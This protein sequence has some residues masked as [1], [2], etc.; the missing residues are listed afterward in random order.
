[1]VA[2]A[3]IGHNVLQSME[4]SRRAAASLDTILDLEEVDSRRFVTAGKKRRWESSVSCSG[5][6]LRA[7]AIAW[8]ETSSAAVSWSGRK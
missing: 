2:M 6:I 3:E 1:M 7:D 8:V 5:S 4:I